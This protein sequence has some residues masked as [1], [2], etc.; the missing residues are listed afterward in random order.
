[1]NKVKW[2][3][4]I[5]DIDGKY[6]LYAKI[7]GDEEPHLY[8]IKVMKVS[9]GYIWEC[10]GAFLYPNDIEGKCYTTELLPPELPEI[11]GL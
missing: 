3:N 10:R 1:M 7:W 2:I 8:I 11:K 9:N 5:P 4:K 6:W